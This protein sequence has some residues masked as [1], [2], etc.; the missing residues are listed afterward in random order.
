LDIDLGSGVKLFGD[1]GILALGALGQYANTAEDEAPFASAGLIGEDG[2]IA[3]PGDTP[4]NNAYLDLTPLL[5]AASLDDVLTEARLELGAISS[6][7]T[8]D[9]GGGAVGDY[10]IADGKLILQSSA[11]AGLSGALSEALDDISD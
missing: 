8:S 11:V 10:Q 6:S 3:L 7:A 1:N 4:E 2:V 9:A 5:E